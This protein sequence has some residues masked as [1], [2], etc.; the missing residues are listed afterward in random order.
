MAIL[1]YV[2]SALRELWRPVKETPLPSD[3]FKIIK[4]LSICKTNS[5]HRGRRAGT[6]V[7]KHV[8]VRITHRLDYTGAHKCKDYTVAHTNNVHRA[9]RLNNLIRIQH[10]EPVE[11]IREKMKTLHMCCVNVRSVKNKTISLA[12]YVVSNDFDVI[13][14][15]ETWLGTSVDAQCLGELVP[16]GYDILHVPRQNNRPGGGVA[17]L[18]KASISLKLLDSTVSQSYSHFEYLDC[19]MEINHQ[20]IYLSVVYR[21]PPSKSN[22]LRNSIFFDEWPLY[23]EKHCTNPSE[24]ILVGDLNFHLDVP[25]NADAQRFLQVLESCGLKQHVLAPTHQKGH[26][27]DV[28][29]TKYASTVITDITISDPGLCDSEGNPS[30]DHM[31]VTFN[32]TLT[33]PSLSRKS[34]SYRKL[35][36]IDINAF[37]SDIKSSPKLN[38]IDGT[39][40][41]LLECYTGGITELVDR[42]APL[43]HKTITLR[44]NAPW[45]DDK[46][47]DAKQKRRRLERKWQKHRIEVHHQI[48]REQCRAVSKLLVETRRR[49]YQNKIAESGSDQKAIYTVVRHLLGQSTSVTLPDYESPQDLANQFSAFFT[50]KIV[51]IR[52][53]F[54]TEPNTLPTETLHTENETVENITH[55][56]EFTQASEDEIRKIISSSS[57]KSC[58]LD[59]LPT[60]LLKDCL[61]QLLPLITVIINKSLQEGVVPT[62][63]KMAHVRPSLK[64]P[65]LDQNILKNYR[66]VS[67]LS[68][69]SKILE[70]VVAK[71]LDHHIDANTLR[72]PFQSAYTRLHSTETAILR[73]QS[74]ILRTLDSGHVAVLVL[75]D[76]SA[77]FDTLDHNILLNR[78]QNSFGITG[79]AH[80][81]VTSYLKDRSQS[82]II[83]GQPSIPKILEFGVPQGSVLGPKM[84]IMYTKTLGQ[85][86]SKHSLDYHMYA[87]DTQL[88]LTFK[89]KDIVCQENAI[90]RLEVCLED[91]MIW[92]KANQLK[93]NSD[94]TEVMFFTPRGYHQPTPLQMNIGD[95]VVTPAMSVRNLG[96]IM[97]QSLTMVNHISSVTRSC[98]MHLRNIGRMRRSLTLDAT[99]T[100]VQGL[101]T[102][103][104][105]YCNAVLSGLPNSTLLRLQRIQNTAARIIT[106]T[107]KCDHITPVLIDLHWL[108]VRRRIEYK[109][110]LY[111]YRALHDN[112]PAYI[113]DMVQSYTPARSLRSQNKL[114]LEVPRSRTAIYGDRSFRTYGPKL[115]NSLPSHL[116]AIKELNP[117]KRALKTH[118]FKL[119]FDV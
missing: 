88:Y 104:L 96:V 29:I 78:F 60:W 70:K 61:E 63:M 87:D 44:P 8:P 115:W 106:R 36:K 66:P 99:K 16:Q 12:D 2:G 17:V 89:K 9:F 30:G 33:K 11:D 4:D 114:Q 97:D 51:N 105:D 107:R 84:Y 25:G 74:D 55:L 35:R 117:F 41:H 85:L 79:I 71:R 43:C 98:Y 24:T 56:S 59:P 54:S 45:Y 111:I 38:N 10:T 58:E 95:T 94:K 21:P 49:Y 52:Q 39:A 81:W 27:L 113:M 108:P 5:T 6:K 90:K 110:L 3:V 14:I 28:L 18:Y 47:R 103:R 46:L 116:R 76:L 101:V 64:K 77:A 93:L 73:V 48:Y 65:G 40:E 26:T 75:L 109:V 53:S 42:H 86:I 83:N 91:I 1:S 37:R 23:L 69:L 82:I 7:H 102:S 92:M 80:H 118:L 112:A 67:N 31:A 57:S 13:A 34:V 19:K 50:D 119:E 32:T 15:T 72:D 100:L 20:T 68:F 22:G 62:A